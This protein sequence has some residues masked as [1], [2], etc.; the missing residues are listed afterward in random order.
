MKMG[1]FE[2]EIVVMLLIPLLFLIA[3]VFVA[4]LIPSLKPI[5]EVARRGILGAI[6]SLPVLLFV[7]YLTR[8][9]RRK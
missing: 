4:M 7:Y 9:L 8:I 6:I 2:K 1:L 3:S 5:S